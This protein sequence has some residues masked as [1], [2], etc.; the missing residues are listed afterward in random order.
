MNELG[1]RLNDL[2]GSATTEVVL[3]DPSLTPPLAVR[4]KRGSSVAFV[5]VAAVA[6]AG[7][8]F[9]WQS[10]DSGTTSVVAGQD[11][12]DVTNLFGAGPCA[13]DPVLE[14]LQAGIP[15]FDYDPAGSYAALAESAAVIVSGTISSVERVVLN[16]RSFLELSVVDVVESRS[17]SPRDDV[18]VIAYDAVW[19]NRSQPDPLIDPV[20]LRDV[21]FV[22]FLTPWSGV[23]GGWTPGVEGLYIA[24]S[25]ND[26][27]RAV[28]AD[29]GGPDDP[30]N[31]S[32][33]SLTDLIAAEAERIIEAARQ[34]LADAVE[35]GNEV[36]L[37][38]NRDNSPADPVVLEELE[39]ARI[40]AGRALWNTSGIVSYRFL[41]MEPSAGDQTRFATLEIEDGLVVDTEFFGVL[42]EPDQVFTVEDLFAIA[43]SADTISELQ[44]H[45]HT[46][47]P[48]EFRVDPDAAVVGDELSLSEIQIVPAQDLADVELILQDWLPEP[49]P[50]PEGLDSFLQR[51][52]DVNQGYLFHER[53]DL[54]VFLYQSG[55]EICAVILA[56]PATGAVGTCRL[57]TDFLASPIRL[58]KSGGT[59][60]LPSYL[61]LVPSLNYRDQ[62]WTAE[63]EG[64][65]VDVTE[66]SVLLIK[67]GDTPQ[68]RAL[69]R[70]LCDCGDRTFSLPG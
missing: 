55:D 18:A 1:K 17:G 38:A 53:D 21:Q 22:G 45:P 31:Q 27:A 8:L 61:L 19:A 65:T 44:L 52:P 39:A 60:G 47:H 43:E 46:G 4:P 26:P 51:T 58:G 23:R 14:L 11:E 16:D 68:G 2:A 9:V 42:D 49:V 59:D 41:Y 37:Q 13:V 3:S 6:M 36:R 32:V 67:D 7:M 56:T 64:G 35:A 48:L 15:T 66:R 25:N 20:V 12:N 50:L 62:E 24:C 70:I 29:G 54:Q 63:A 34:D 30:P 57:M 40:E 33:S 10:S 5:L 69:I 28:I